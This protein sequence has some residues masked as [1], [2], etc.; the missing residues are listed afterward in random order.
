MP[1]RT[2]LTSRLCRC[3]SCRSP[4][5]FS[6]SCGGRVLPVICFSA[7]V[8]ARLR[9]FA[10]ARRFGSAMRSA[11]R[12]D[13]GSMSRGGPSPEDGCGWLD[14]LMDV[15]DLILTSSFRGPIEAFR[16][17]DGSRRPLRATEVASDPTSA[18]SAFIPAAHRRPGVRG[19]RR[20]EEIRRDC[21]RGLSGSA[22]K[23][24]GLVTVR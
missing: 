15:M 10:G 23:A 13:C 9:G 17:Y 3:S 12:V 19:L 4:G 16:R 20:S 6:R 1:F 5:C 11:A 2:A 24:V 18:S 8:W 14:G 7:C 22:R 21:A